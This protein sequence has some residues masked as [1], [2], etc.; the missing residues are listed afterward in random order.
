MAPLEVLLSHCRIRLLKILIL[1][2]IHNYM[3]FMS[4]EG[5]QTYKYG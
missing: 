3:N 1:K 2:A 5:T 4:Q